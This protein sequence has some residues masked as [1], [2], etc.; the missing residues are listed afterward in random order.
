MKPGA[1]AIV[2]CADGG[3][4]DAAAVDPQP[5]RRS[6]AAA[7]VE[8]RAFIPMRRGS[9]PK[10]SDTSSQPPDRTPLLVT[11][12]RAEQTAATPARVSLSAGCGKLVAPVAATARL[13]EI[14]AGRSLAS[15]GCILWVPTGRNRG[16]EPRGFVVLGGYVGCEIHDC[17][18]W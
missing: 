6:D 17:G 11:S 16:R 3:G 12:P 18:A 10:G 15:N 1:T 4:W 7:R 5:A 2:R 8:A 13:L 14:V 9:W